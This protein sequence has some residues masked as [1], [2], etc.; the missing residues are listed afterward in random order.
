MF[1]WKI[2]AAIFAVLIVAASA[3]VSNSEIKDMFLNST[4]TLG[5]WM[6]GSPFGSLFS[7]PEKTTSDVVITL[8]GGNVQLVIDK[9]VNITSE[10][11]SVRNFMGTMDII[12]DEN[13]TMLVPKDSDLVLDLQLEDMEVKN[14]NVPSL[15]LERM[16]FV[17]EYDNTNITGTDEKIEIHDFYGDLKITDVIELS[18]NVSKVKNDKWSIG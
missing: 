15:V 18:G 9:P 17:V 5:D 3:L 16:D 1:E 12:L 7:A 10:V 2:L 8:S 14:V 4:G 6:K 11:S 13:K